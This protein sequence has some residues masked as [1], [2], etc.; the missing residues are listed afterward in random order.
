MSDSASFLITLLTQLAYQSPWLLGCVGGLVFF[1]MRRPAYGKAATWA[2]A[3]FGLFLFASVAGA[4]ASG[5]LQQLMISQAMPSA[6]IS[7]LFGVLGVVHALLDT[8]ALLLLG[9]AVVQGRQS[10]TSEFVP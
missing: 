8:A 9:K 5:L 4:L 6:T 1:L 7:I 10:P 2:A 3:G